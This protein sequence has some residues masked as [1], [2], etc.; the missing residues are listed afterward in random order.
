MFTD[1]QVGFLELINNM[2]TTG[3]VPAL[4]LDDEKKV[5]LS[6]IRDEVIILGLP[7]TKDIMW[8]FFINIC[9]DNLHIILCIK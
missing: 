4:Y 3:M 7:Q 2:L 1:V 6:S 8:Q 9:A 5:L